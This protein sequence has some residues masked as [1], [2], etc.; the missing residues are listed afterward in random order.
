MATSPSKSPSKNKSPP[1][2]G[3]VPTSANANAYTSVVDTSNKSDRVRAAVS[4][5]G[6]ALARVPTAQEIEKN[7]IDIAAINEFLHDTCDFSTARAQ[8]LA[9]VL[10]VVYLI[11]SISKLKKLKTKGKQSHAAMYLLL[12]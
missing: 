11:G 8:E 10:V 7:K 5:T 12:V 4:T 1:G 6:S 2:G 3:G 9:D